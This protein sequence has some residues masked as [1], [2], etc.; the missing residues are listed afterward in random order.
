M[1]INNFP[2]P[3]HPQK[4]GGTFLTNYYAQA[5]ADVNNGV[6]PVLST[7]TSY[8]RL[9]GTVPIAN[10][11][12]PATIIDL[13]IP[14]PVGLTN[15]MAALD[16]DLTNGW[17]QGLTYLGSFVEGSANDLNPA[18]GAFEFDISMLD[19]KGATS[20]TIT[21]NYSKSPAGTHNAITLTS[22]FADPIALPPFIP[23]GVDSVG[24][25]NIV[26]DTI[27]WFDG[28]VN[29]P[30]LGGYVAA[31]A[32]AY[33]G[34]WEPYTGLLGDSTFLLSANSYADDGM[35]MRFTVVFQPATGGAAKLGDLFYDDS[36]KPYTNK[37]NESRQDGN[38][39]RVAGDQRLGA[40]NFMGGGEVSLYNYPTFFDSDGRF[41][42][43]SPFYSTLASA[44]Q[45]GRDACVQSY[46]L[47]VTTLEQTMLSK[48]QDSAFG[49]C[50]TNASYPQSGNNQISRF[51]G[52]IQGLD[53]GNFVSMVEDRSGIFNPVNPDSGH[54][55]VATIFAPN[56]SIVK[57]A[58]AVA[59][60]N[61]Q[62]ANLAAYKGGFE[63]RPSGGQIYFF[64]NA[65]NLQ[66]SVD[67]NATS[68]LAYDTGRGDGTRTASEIRSGVSGG[69]VWLSI[70]D[71]LTRAFVTKA[72]VSEGD[73]SVRTLD[74]VNLAVDALDRVCVVYKVKPVAADFPA[75][76]TA[77]RVMAFDGTNV[78]YLT[79]SFFPFVNHD[80]VGD[81]TIE[82]D[83]PSVAMTTRQIFVSAKGVVNSTN[84]PA[85]GGDTAPN[86][87][88][89]TVITHPDPQP[90]PPV[91]QSMAR[92]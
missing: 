35:S 54:A 37:I 9:V 5:L 21:A 46:S 47:N 43:S 44:P 58:F 92:P 76:Q 29:R 65:G 72:V 71:A 32:V 61:D 67:H 50:C 70:W 59:N 84:N 55:S 26:A 24:L 12:F 78:T 22:P 89:Y 28:S 31:N 36:G 63:V 88:L 91:S 16:P 34:S 27:V 10:T 87:S 77:A 15:G 1:L 66:G 68:G 38:P 45:G 64:D 2:F 81:L 19:L 3:V 69:Q 49:R 48:A 11:N 40:T 42:A 57:E 56:G 75:F 8:S 83:E 80:R 13:Y 25:S 33:M 23:G 39:G 4:G 41:D 30:K 18:T 90:T 7:N 51:G 60:N 73:P 74:R 82:T 79:R 62:W 86:T 17:V 85:G 53:N 14:D 52:H 20:L 6:A